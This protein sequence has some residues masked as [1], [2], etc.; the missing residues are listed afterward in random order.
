MEAPIGMEGKRILDY[1]DKTRGRRTLEKMFNVV[2]DHV[3]EKLEKKG[4]FEVSLTLVSP[5][6]QKELNRAYR[7]IDRETDVLTFAYDETDKESLP[8][9]DLGTITICPEVAKRQAK[10]FRHPYE[11][12]LAFLFIHGLLH[13]FGYD[14]QTDVDSQKMFALQN[15]ILNTLP[16]DFY[17]NQKR[18]LASLLEAQSHAVVPYSHFRV[19]AVVV[20]KDGKYITGFN[21]ENSSYP[22][23]CCAERVALYSAY[24]QGYRKEDIVALGCITD[25]KN[26]G[27][28]CGVCRQV[29]SELMNLYAPVYIYSGDGKQH[30]F[31]TVEGLL[32]HP[33]TK[34]DME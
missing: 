11:R 30:L 32:P 1:L 8:I 22:A 17:T 24:A 7:K 29:M 12:E 2:F 14:H 21:I 28:C 3:L 18:L 33:F 6:E 34:E 27:T 13:I 23:T 31:T 4:D 19:G 16:F 15:E 9:E 26:V 25:S 5:E 10:E 20:T